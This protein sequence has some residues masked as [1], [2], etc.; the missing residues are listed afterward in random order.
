MF[1]SRMKVKETGQ[2]SGCRGCLPLRRSKEMSGRRYIVV[3]ENSYL[4]LVSSNSGGKACLGKVLM[5]HP[6]RVRERS[7]V[8][9]K[10]AELRVLEVLERDRW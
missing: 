2:G 6:A 10:R 4:C 9:I 8:N 7:I 3:R 1:C 5:S